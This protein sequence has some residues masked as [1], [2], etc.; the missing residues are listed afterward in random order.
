MKEK[1]I[2]ILENSY[3]PYS[4]FR[5]ASILVTKDGTEFRGV[6]VEN[7]SYGAAICSERTAI[8]SAVAAGYKKGD[9]KELYVMCDNEK[10]GMPCFVC[11]QVMVEFFEKDMRIVAMNPAGESLTYTAEELCP[12]PFTEDDLK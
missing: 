12:Y 6:N 8:V 2:K 7:A 5:V 10:I 1:L 4:H 9:F 3:S 11:R